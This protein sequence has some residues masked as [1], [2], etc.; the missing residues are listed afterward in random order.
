M[1]FA[2]TPRAGRASRARRA[3][4]LEREPPE[5]TLG[6]SWPSSAGRASSVAEERRR[7]R[8]RLPR[9]GGA[10][11]GA[12]ARALPRAA[13]G[14][15]SALRCRPARR[16]PAA[17]AA[18]DASWTLA[19]GPLVPDLTPRRASRSSAATRSGELDGAEREVL[20]TIDE[21]PAARRRLRRR[22]GHARSAAPT[23]CPRCGRARSTARARGGRR[24][25][26]ARSSSASSTRRRASSSAS[27]SAS[28]RPSRI[29]SRARYARRRA[30]AL[31]RVLGGLVRRRGRPA[32][33]GRG[34]RGEGVRR[35]G[36]RRR[37]R[38]LDP[39][40]RRHRLHVGA[41][42]APALQARALDRGLRRRPRRSC[43]PRSPSHLLERMR[44]DCEAGAGAR[45]PRRLC[46]GRPDDG[47]PAQR[48]GDPAPRRRAVRRRARSSRRLPDKSWHRYTYAD[49]VSRT[50]QLVVALRELGLER[51]RPRR[52]RSCGTTT[53]IS[54][55]TSAHRSAA[56][57]R[58]R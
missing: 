25:A 51:R 57:S 14:R 16:G 1:D 8:A 2:F 34:G 50:K 58:T 53:S 52:R 32:G 10:A 41:P 15:P 27:R 56:S 42:A 29:R 24:R 7:R 44:R 26:R 31:A 21:T 35:R 6:T 30:R 38:A 33:A 4:F 43:A 12:R 39:G 22:G 11:R 28:T 23:C 46:R 13:T 49:F 36:R 45:R 55:R 20:A 37:V 17:V 3:A 54:R 9:G 19:L 48:A 5:P 47:L 40:A 18:G